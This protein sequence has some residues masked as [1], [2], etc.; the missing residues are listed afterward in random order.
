MSIKKVVAYGQYIWS[1]IE[2]DELRKERCLCLN[3]SRRKEQCARAKQFYLI[4]KD[5]DMAMMIT[6]CREFEEQEA[7]G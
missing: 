1:D 2:M 7:Q 3:C 6:R 5:Y 4:C